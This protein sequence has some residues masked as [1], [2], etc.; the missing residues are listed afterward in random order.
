M[1]SAEP[2]QIDTRS[3]AFE[4]VCRSLGARPGHYATKLIATKISE[5]SKD[6]ISDSDELSRRVLKSLNLLDYP[7]PVR[8]PALPLGPC[9]ISWPPQEHHRGTFDAPRTNAL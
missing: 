6:G 1:M 8:E 2:E 9:G 5:L 4:T 7:N 3:E